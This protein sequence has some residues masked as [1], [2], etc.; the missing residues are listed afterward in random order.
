[1]Q[2]KIVETGLNNWFVQFSTMTKF[3]ECSIKVSYLHPY[4]FR[5]SSYLVLC[6]VAQ[7]LGQ[8]VIHDGNTTCVS[9]YV[10]S[11]YGHVN[12]PVLAR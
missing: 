3:A 6:C 1:M 4:Y 12:G 7:H 11:S 2:S 5:K 9:L 10:I 8:E